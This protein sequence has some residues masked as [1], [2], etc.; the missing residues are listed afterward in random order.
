MSPFCNIW[1]TICGGVLDTIEEGGKRR[2][3]IELNPRSSYELI[4]GESG[5]VESDDFDPWAF[6]SSILS[7]RDTEVRYTLNS[8]S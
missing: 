1:C 4:E 2:S 6:N 5:D 7:I 8:S 3:Q